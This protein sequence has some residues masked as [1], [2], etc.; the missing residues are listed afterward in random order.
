MLR[1]DS[2]IIQSPSKHIPP[3]NNIRHQYYDKSTYNKPIT[4]IQAEFSTQLGCH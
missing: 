1:I 3:V 4:N 2:A